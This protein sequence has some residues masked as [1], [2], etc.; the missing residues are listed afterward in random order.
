MSDKLRIPLYGSHSDWGKGIVI[1]SSDCPDAVPPTETGDLHEKLNQQVDKRYLPNDEQIG[2]IE[3]E[4][5]EVIDWDIE[6]PM[7]ET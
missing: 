5:G 4:D 1:K 3:I 6:I 2:Y 7:K